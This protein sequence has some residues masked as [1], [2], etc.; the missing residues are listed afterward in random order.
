MR[1]AGSLGDRPVQAK[2]LV[3]VGDIQRS[4]NNNEVGWKSYAL[5]NRRNRM[6]FDR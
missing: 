2:C 5:I 1:A 4:Q 6:M 3:T